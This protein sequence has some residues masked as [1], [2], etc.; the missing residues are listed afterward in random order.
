MT[1]TMTS[2]ICTLQMNRYIV[3]KNGISINIFSSPL[4]MWNKYQALLQTD[5]TLKDFVFLL[6]D[7]FSWWSNPLNNYENYT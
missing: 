2:L 3:G 4:N 1:F 6:E 7:F 5:T